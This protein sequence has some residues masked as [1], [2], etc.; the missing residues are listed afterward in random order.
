MV[1][2]EPRVDN[3]VMKEEEDIDD[4]EL[5]FDPSDIVSLISLTAGP[6]GRKKKVGENWYAK[7]KQKATSSIQQGYSLY[8]SLV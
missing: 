8:K 6:D 5:D 7:G 1:N 3:E 4:E 2:H